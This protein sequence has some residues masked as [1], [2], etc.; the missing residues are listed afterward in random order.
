MLQKYKT[1]KRWNEPG[2]AHFLTFSCFHGYQLLSRDRTRQ[3]L[4]E[5]ID[6]ARRRHAWDVW[7]YV[8]MPEHV[9]LIVRPQ[10]AIYDI[11]VLL[12]AIKWP[13][14]I[15]A[16]KYL[17]RTSREW[18]KRLTDV[19]PNG[20]FS[21]RFW[22]RGGGFD[23]NIRQERSL[24]AM[25]EYIHANPVRRELVR[26]PCEWAWSSARWYDGERDVP[27]QMDDTLI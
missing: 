11:S 6:R 3:W 13:V 15:R 16:R 5:A 1:C 12:K 23:R 7:A 21:F 19:Q 8:I 27:L 26:E 22:Q 4:V 24:G 20:E 10:N 14:S 17:E 2:D 25:I 18:M 9:H